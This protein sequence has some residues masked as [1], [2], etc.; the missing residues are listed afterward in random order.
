MTAALDHI[1][2]VTRKSCTSNVILDEDEYSLCSECVGILIPMHQLC[3]DFAKRTRKPS[4]L[5]SIIVQNRPLTQYLARFPRALDDNMVTH[6]GSAHPSIK[7]ENET[8]K[9][10]D[11]EDMDSSEVWGK[12]ICIMHNGSGITLN[13]N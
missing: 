2:E 9:Y 3:L 8:E 12:F 13:I 5:K 11:N 7:L 6:S 10:T 1:F 4:F